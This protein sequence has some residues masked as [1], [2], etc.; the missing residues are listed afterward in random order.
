MW[1]RN[2]D[3]TETARLP[4]IKCGSGGAGPPMMR[5]GLP[6]TS[7]CPNSKSYSHSIRRA[8]VVSGGA[9]FRSAAS[10]SQQ[11]P[12]LI[13]ERSCRMAKT[14]TVNITPI[15]KKESRKRKKNKKKRNFFIIFVKTA[16]KKAFFAEKANR[17]V[18]K[19]KVFP[20]RYA[21][22]NRNDP[23]FC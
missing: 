15:L 8:A 7:I 13:C 14:L 4:G 12:K 16:R 2:P 9:F 23:F 3:R 11:I 6:S 17:S 21:S 22:V 1:K 5:S 19:E 20:H 10:F 18:Q